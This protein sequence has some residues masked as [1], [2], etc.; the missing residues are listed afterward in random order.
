VIVVMT[1]LLA[2]LMLRHGNA[3]SFLVIGLAV[4]G[5]ATL[6]AWWLRGIAAGERT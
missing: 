6:G 3:G 1:V 2:M 4:I 5:G